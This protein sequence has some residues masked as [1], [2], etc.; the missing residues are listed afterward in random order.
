M[1]KNH[2]NKILFSFHF[3]FL[4]NPGCRPPA[5]INYVERVFQQITEIT[6]TR[7]AGTWLIFLPAFGSFEDS[8]SIQVI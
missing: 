8:L 4:P 5:R 7:G 6:Q 2:V 3:H 1:Q